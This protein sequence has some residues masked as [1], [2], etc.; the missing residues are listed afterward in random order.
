MSTAK[1]TAAQELMLMGSI[2]ESQDQDDFV[3][4][5]M[6]AVKVCGFET[7]LIGLEL[8]GANGQPI[9]HV[10]SA[11][12]LSWQ[13]HYSQQGY[14]ASDPTVAYCQKS[15]QPLVWNEGIFQ[16]A[17]CMP[18]FEEARHHGV[19]Y[20]ISLSVH[21][22]RGNKSMFSLARDQT[23]ESSTAEKERLVAF[24]QILSSCIHVVAN[25]LIAPHVLAGASPGLSKKERECL[26]WVA[27]GK[28]AWEIGIIM[29]ISEPTVVF[30]LKN[31]MKKL[32]VVNRYQALAV[33]LRLGLVG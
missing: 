2:F 7:F 23:L 21:E 13:R 4:Q 14:A 28:T 27:N 19:S 6:K 29:R 33:A 16:D 25:R 30:H 24:A 3:V 10:T 17:G 8:R 22:E 5:I 18:L 1:P 11:Y 26:Q 12:P 20:G 32:D 15:I 9:Q 31:V